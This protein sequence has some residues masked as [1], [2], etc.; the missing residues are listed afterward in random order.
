MKPAPFGLRH[1]L[2]FGVVAFVLANGVVE[3]A[4]RPTVGL[5]L[6]GG[7]ARGAAH[8]GVL[9]VLRENHVQIDC[10]AGTSMGGLVS[11]AFAAG[12]T[13]AEMMVAMKQANWRDMFNDSPPVSEFDPRVRQ[14][15]RRFLP[16]S[17]LGVT[18]NG[19][20]ALPGVVSGQK[21]K[22]FFNKLIRSENG[23]PQIE[24][25]GMPASIVA[26]DLVSGN[27]VVFK[28]GSLSKAMRASMS[29]PGLMSPVEDA[30]TLLV[31]G[32]LV[33]NV[34]I[35]EV[36]KSC[37]PDVVI[38]VNVGSPLSKANEIGSLLSVAGQMVN[39]LTEQNVTKSLATLRPNDI[40]IKP[41][42]DGITAGDFERYAETAERGRVAA[43]AVVEQLR[44]LSGDPVQYDKW[45][46][47]VAP[48]R[49]PGPTIDSIEVV[50]LKRYDREVVAA[51]FSKFEGSKLKAD[52]LDSEIMRMYGENEFDT[53]DYSLLPSR[54][55]N[56]LR[57]AP[58]EKEFGPDYI[59]SGINLESVLGGQSVFNIR[60]A[61]HKTWLNSF[62][63]EWLTGVQIG[64]NPKFFTEFYQPLDRH[65]R[66]FIEPA[67]SF[68]RDPI[69][70]YQN[71]NKIAEY[72]V[73]E[74]R[75]DLMAGVNF[76]PPGS[77]RLGW[78][79]RDRKASLETGT[80]AISS[81]EKRFGGW[82]ARLDLEQ[83]DRLFMP[84]HGWSV[85]GS[86]FD[87]PSEN[88]S[89]AE[90]DLRA[91]ENIRDV[92]FHGRLYFAGSPKGNLPAFDPARLGGFLNMSGF[93]PNQI[94]GDSVNFGSVRVEKIVGELPLGLRG[95]MRI[96][97]SLERGKVGGRF[98]ETEL[99]GWQNSLAVYA[100]G[101][102]P[103]GPVYAGYGYSPNGMSLVY[104]FIGTP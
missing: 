40:Y 1:L 9:E 33:D 83:L 94:F 51:R 25:L 47:S 45:W 48:D 49:G 71:N 87:S 41:D 91:S 98:S 53:V 62:G 69:G 75:A 89:K 79:E 38:A 24:K 76:G 35:D 88:Y 18:K 20:T 93:S 55:R 60:G 22:L 65:R 81:G 74:F 90:L 27:K 42:L 31:D 23:E 59:R 43:Q 44:R 17:E 67:I 54:E 96:G 5:V 14:V 100:G 21:I 82:M 37:N 63:G 8:I 58:V 13:P 57:I 19:A 52:K 95:D 6:G 4:N 103:L 68:Q 39:I 92:I 72:R 16:G 56:I 101:E 50:E 78:V 86:Y 73:N 46:S 36:R 77:I 30:G 102:T 28:Q 84:T 85:K 80:P 99:N 61:Y 97:M 11:G 34:P 29:V 66:F 7:G 26:T 70:I 15:S 32:G 12:L 104:V 2:F 3:A 10:V 64:N